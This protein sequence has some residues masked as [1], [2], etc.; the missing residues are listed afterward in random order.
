MGSIILETK[1]ITNFL[2]TYYVSIMQNITNEN[3]KSA[4]TNGNIIKSNN[5]II[6]IAIEVNRKRFIYLVI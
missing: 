6:N 4:M 1:L 3:D 5:W 2:A